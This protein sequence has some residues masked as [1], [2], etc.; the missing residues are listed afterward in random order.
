MSGVI[1]RMSLYPP[2][3]CPQH[4]PH[5]TR[6]PC[7]TSFVDLDVPEP[8]FHVA[9]KHCPWRLERSKLR[10]LA[11][12]Q[13]TRLHIVKHKPTY[14]CRDGIPRYGPAGNGRR[15]RGYAYVTWFAL[16]RRY[17]LPARIRELIGPIPGTY[18]D[19]ETLRTVDKTRE[20]IFAGEPPSSR[21][22]VPRPQ[23]Q[24]L[25]MSLP[26]LPC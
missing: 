18:I 8:H 3:A 6:L 4:G 22:I 2:Q 26:P 11:E 5:H 14:H 13:F 19:V 23:E 20:R 25:G 21:L 10:F 12:R 16:L 9:A 7:E 15:W 1:S 17:L 24:E